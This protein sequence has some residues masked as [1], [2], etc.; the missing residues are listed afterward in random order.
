MAYQEIIFSP[1]EAMQTAL[2][3]VNEN[4]V[5]LYN[6]PVQNIG[7]MV[8]VDA[9]SPTVCN[10]DNTKNIYYVDCTGG[11]V[12]ALF[13]VSTFGNRVVC[14]IRT[15]NSAYKFRIDEVTGTPT[16]IG[17]AIPYDTG[18]LQY[19]SVDITYYNNVFYI[20]G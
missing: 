8:G 7:T 10:V 6:N 14:F 12:T 1:P 5:E 19:E 2:T 18:L 11:D 16:V 13:D 17:N 3:K 15:D 20:K 9:A 4:F